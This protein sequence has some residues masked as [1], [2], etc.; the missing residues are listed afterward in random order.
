MEIGTKDAQFIFWEYINRI[1]FAVCDKFI[2]LI[3]YLRK[4]YSILGS[5]FMLLVM[6]LQ[7]A[8][9]AVQR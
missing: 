5:C 4:K 3:H 9:L 8:M 7:K 2:S 1:V 6:T